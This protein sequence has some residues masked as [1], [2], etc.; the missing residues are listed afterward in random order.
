M[1]EAQ[2]LY[3]AARKRVTTHDLVGRLETSAD[4]EEKDTIGQLWAAR[5]K[6]R[7]GFVLATM[8][9]LQAALTSFQ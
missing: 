6:G 8:K 1:Q 4:T 3:T 9:N 7:C 5:S 2:K